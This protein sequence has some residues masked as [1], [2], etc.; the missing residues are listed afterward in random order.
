MK[1]D[2]KIKELAKILGTDYNNLFIF[3]HYIHNSELKQLE[4]EGKLGIFKLK[5]MLEGFNKA[6]KSIK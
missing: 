1:Q 6:Y 3:L 4:A 2:I 5:Y